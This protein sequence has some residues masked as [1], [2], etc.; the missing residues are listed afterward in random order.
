M[1]NRNLIYLF[2]LSAALVCSCEKD[3]RN[4]IINPDGDKKEDTGGGGSDTSDLDKLA[5]G[6]SV[7]PE[8]PSSDSSCTLYYR[9][10]GEYPFSGYTGDLYAH[11]G[12]VN[13]QWEHVQAEWTE[14]ID[15]C[16]WQ[17]TDAKDIWS[18][19]IEPSI[20][21]WFGAGEDEAITKIG[22][23]VR[24]ADGTK[25]T[26][27]LFCKVE[28]SERE[29]KPSDVVMESVP[30]GLQKGIN[31]ISDT[32][33]GLVLLERDKD[34]A[35]YEH[36]L[37]VGDFNDWNLSHSYEMRRDETAGC[38]W[39]KLSDLQAG[40]EYR[41]QYHLIDSEG[42]FVRLADPYTE[43]TYSSDDK[44]IS[45]STYPDMPTYPTG[46]GGLVSAFQ[47]ARPEYAWKVENYNV[48]DADDLVIY[49]LHLRDFSS[50][51]DLA[52]A[53]SHLDYLQSL[54]VNAIELM[55]VQ[56]FDGN[57][58]W[59]YSPCG[60]FSL[61]KAYGTRDKYKEFIDECHSRGIAV[62]F[63]VVYNH[64]TGAHPMAKMYWN[65]STNKTAAN[66]PWFNVDAPHPYSVFHDWNHENAEVREYIKSSLE[67]LLDEYHIDGFR[68]DL[69]KGFTQKNSSESTC[70]N[71]DASRIAILK[72]YASAVFAKKSDA[73]V[74]FEHFCATSEEN[75]LAK[76]GIKLWRN[77]NNAYCQTAMGWLSDGDDF[78]SMWTGSSMPFGSLVGFQES[79]DEERTAYK[80]LKW[81]NGI[82]GNL[83]ARMTREELNAAFSL[84]IPGPKMIWQFEELGYDVSIEYNDRTGA[85]PLHWDYYEVP[86]RKA[87]YDT[88]S[89]LLEFR[90]SH[91]EFF[92][93]TATYTAQMGSGWYYRHISIDDGTGKAFY[94]VGNFYIADQNVDVTFPSAGTW[95]DY[96]T[97]EKYTVGSGKNYTFSIPA[98]GFKLLTN[99]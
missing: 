79:H 5:Y 51:K 70:S 46:A 27:D 24:N 45:S 13:L 61:D 6:L 93:S 8:N 66:N 96:F 87:L 17:K 74:I 41:F 43:I 7:V 49:E 30:A 72:D 76:S 31:Y 10:G 50:T 32:E 77:M 99:F 90:F 78:S 29:F 15:K 73:V 9:A 82:T 53:G 69:T 34:G 63:D 91:P 56:E 80:S 75:E 71:Y 22:V 1:K 58:S 81:G 25:Q 94:L 18:L 12:I 35:R 2:L 64:V 59:G 42:N 28:D 26:V 88:Y 39:I 36:A 19:S 33:V 68:F 40:K 97:G 65:S 92:K 83:A 44:W 84:L 4:T 54:G 98:G 86:E 47:T 3:N 52:G 38:W 85:K 95:K 48:K 16:R 21:E 62:L 57:D 37:V 23:V 14:N 60:Y 11:I 20:R 67:Y 89:D 55:P